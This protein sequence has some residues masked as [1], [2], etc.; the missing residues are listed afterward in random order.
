MDLDNNTIDKKD[1]EDHP[2]KDPAYF[3]Y[4]A[5]LTHQVNNGNIKSITEIYSFNYFIKKYF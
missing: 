1:T 3:N 4:Y 2:E 5:Q